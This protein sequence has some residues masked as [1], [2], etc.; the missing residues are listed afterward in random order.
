MPK[1]NL[2]LMPTS[3]AEF[4]T[5]KDRE[6]ILLH[7]FLQGSIDSGRDDLSRLCTKLVRW[8]EKEIKSRKLEQS[9]SDFYNQQLC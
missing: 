6:I 5:L 4:P 3:Q 2:T 9:L 7:A 1:K 8:T